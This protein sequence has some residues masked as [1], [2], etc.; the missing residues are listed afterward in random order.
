MLRAGIALLILLTPTAS[1]QSNQPFRMEILLEKEDHGKAVVVE[2]GHVFEPGDR[3]RFRFTPNFN[4]TLFVMDKGTSGSYTMLFPKEETGTNDK[5]ESGKSYL[6]PSTDKGWFRISGPSGYDIVYFVV[7]SAAPG[8]HSTPSVTSVPVPHLPAASD[9]HEPSSM[10]PR[11]NDDLF[12]AR[13]DCIDLS[14]GP[15]KAGD[16]LPENLSGLKARDLFFIRK[17]K[18]SVVSSTAP[19]D[20]PAV[21]EFH[22]AHK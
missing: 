9:T 19:L 15:K 5:L 4:G 14:A 6:L 2:P 17:E 13:G 3:L 16:A 22:V 1:G 21:F 18:A 8:A 7:T 10:T 12:R 11:C 20:Q